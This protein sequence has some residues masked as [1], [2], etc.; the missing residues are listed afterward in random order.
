VIWLPGSCVLAPHRYASG[1][2]KY[3]EETH[4]HSNILVYTIRGMESMAKPELEK[5]VRL[6]TYLVADVNP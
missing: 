5:E 6:N 3:K 4:I 2:M 1:Q